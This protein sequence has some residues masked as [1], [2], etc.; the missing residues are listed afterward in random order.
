MGIKQRCHGVGCLWEA[1]EGW[2]AVYAGASQG[3][4]C[5]SGM[6]LLLQANICARI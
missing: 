1:W 5:K 4:M 2:G 6:S 3:V